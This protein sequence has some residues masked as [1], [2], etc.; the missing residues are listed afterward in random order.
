MGS[1]QK[2]G[3]AEGGQHS[4]L[5]CIEINLL[6]SEINKIISYMYGIKKFYCFFLTKIQ[7]LIPHTCRRLI[8][9]HASRS[10]SEN[11]P[12]TKIVHQSNH[13]NYLTWEIYNKYRIKTLCLGYLTV[14]YKHDSTNFHQ[15][16]SH[17]RQACMTKNSHISDLSSLTLYKTLLLQFYI[18][19]YKV[20]T[21]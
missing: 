5:V 10:K 2:W 19:H 11:S 7:Y 17:T 14:T 1:S 20:T 15:H 21:Q 3:A 13:E 9:L 12:C 16:I 6:P 8:F 4:L 18:L